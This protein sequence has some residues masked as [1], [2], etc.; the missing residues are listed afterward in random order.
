MRPGRRTAAIVPVLGAFVLAGCAGLPARER[1]A[2]P[3]VHIA[4]NGV[5]SV[6]RD[7]LD[8]SSAGEALRAQGIRTADRIRVEAEPQTL[9][10]D[11]KRVLRDLEDAGYTNTRF[12]QAD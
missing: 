4:S 3:V 1:P 11:I 2:P 6:G 10:R 12:H 8:A 9:H 7:V 5:V